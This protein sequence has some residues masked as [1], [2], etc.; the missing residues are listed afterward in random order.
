MAQATSYDEAIRSLYEKIA[1]RE[2]FRYEYSADPQYQAYRQNYMKQGRRAMQDSMAQAA[3]LTG[4]YGSSYAQS[5]GSEAYAS[6]LEKLNMALPELYSAAY[7]RYK[8]E[9]DALQAQLESAM[10]LGNMEY[11]RGMDE[12]QLALD[13][14]QFGY[15]V[16]KD[17]YDRLFELISNTGYLPGEEE[18]AR[19]GMSPEQ[20]LAL[21]NEFLRK[22]RLLPGSATSSGGGSGSGGGTPGYWER[23]SSQNRVFTPNPDPKPTGEGSGVTV[24]KQPEDYTVQTRVS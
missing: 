15:Q 24:T 23:L 20:A 4:G 14:E 7:Q 17:D 19:G 1:G 11:Q 3:Q 13:K 22:N 18:L 5:V 16:Y 2:G 8:G 21:S 12:K 6:Y 9:G 10:A